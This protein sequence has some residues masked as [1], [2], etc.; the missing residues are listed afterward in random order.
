MSK[1]SLL[2]WSTIL[3]FIDLF[4]DITYKDIPL[5]LIFWFGLLDDLEKELTQPGY[6]LY[7]KNRINSDKEIQ[8]CFDK[9]LKPL[10]EGQKKEKRKGKIFL[11]NNLLFFPHN[12][13]ENY[14]VPW[15]TNMLIVNRRLKPNINDIAGVPVIQIR[16]GYQ[17]YYPE[18]HETAKRFQQSAKDIISSVEHPVFRKPEIIDRFIEEIPLMLELIE[19]FDKYFTENPISC[20]VVG[21]T[22]GEYPL[23]RI[24]SLLAMKK[25]IP[26]ICMQHGLNITGEFSFLPVFTSKLAVYG[27]WEKDWYLRK[28]VRE[29]DIEIIGHPR[30]DNIFLEKHLPKSN[31]SDKYSLNG[32]KKTILMI[33]QPV[34][35][36]MKVW[37][38]FLYS[39][40]PHFEV[41]I[42]P[43][44]KETRQDNVGKYNF[45][46][47]TYPSVRIINDLQLY[48]L[49]PNVDIVVI[50]SSTVGLE[51]MLF[52]K[53]VFILNE[54]HNENYNYYY[55]IL[56]QLAYCDSF[57]LP[58]TLTRLISDKSFYRYA[59]SKREEFL[60]YHY[61][62]K[63]SSP[64]LINLINKL[65]CN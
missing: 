41:L 28:G 43:H 65:T 8:P 19:K 40:P 30:F 35:N 9:Y 53:P 32:E 11:L 23:P 46:C 15:K 3:D 21:T 26:S 12:I 56:D 5:P 47:A 61:P 20:L 37:N 14:F 49:L 44:P 63:L 22:G 64:L 34:E 4:Q 58:S 48:D 38:Q 33:T 31:F 60:A 18:L 55:K 1:T 36:N 17:N 25:G 54:D 2:C 7:L 42:R 39:L 27:Y 29:E 10:K 24:L 16:S 13:L 51:A 6:A 57:I 52:D 62:N 45:F 50:N 59:K